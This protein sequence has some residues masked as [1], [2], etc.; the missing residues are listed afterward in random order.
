[1]FVV[2][3]IL[4]A[5]VAGLAAT[6][7]ADERAHVELYRKVHRS[8]VG[9]SDG[10]QKGSGVLIDPSGLILTS[11]TAMRPD[12]TTAKV[13][14]SDHRIVTAE[15]VALVLS[16]ELIILKAEVGDL[17]AIALGDSDAVKAGDSSY[18]FGDSFNSIFSDGEVAVSLGIVS[19]VYSIS[20][21]LYPGSTYLGK[22]IETSAAVNPNQD[23]APLV[24]AEGRLIG[25]VTLNFTDAKF[26]GLAIPINEIKPFIERVKKGETIVDEEFDF[27]KLDMLGVVLR[28]TA[29]GILV[30]F[31]D[32]DTPAASAGLLRG[33][34]IS[35]L[36][37][38][39]VKD[40]RTIRRHLL[41]ARPEQV[42]L[43]VK[44]YGVPLE[45]TVSL[46]RNVKK[47]Y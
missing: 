36:E 33:D 42:R 43:T 39:P 27:K 16:R 15:R 26:A 25:M 40:L 30:L 13:H 35:G 24:D 10:G 11:T 31:V 21:I 23:G 37:G 6:P 5:T 9:I 18:V 7:P 19:G 2:T 41:N 20:S 44:R 22:V 4:A 45:L 8:V 12:S 17:P 29:E 14:L 46:K 32:S 38:A 3:A 47:D 28:D 34:I 1:M